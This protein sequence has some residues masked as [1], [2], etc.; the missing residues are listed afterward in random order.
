MKAWKFVIPGN[1]K[2][3]RVLQCLQKTGKCRPSILLENGKMN[4]FWKLVQLQQV[5]IRRRG[6]KKKKI[7]RPSETSFAL[8]SEKQERI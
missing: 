3:Y 2:P 7:T 6:G 1:L 4:S 5:I 8:V